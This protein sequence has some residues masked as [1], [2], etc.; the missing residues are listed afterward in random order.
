MRRSPCCR[1]EN[2]RGRSRARG[3]GARAEQALRVGP[4]RPGRRIQRGT[5]RDLRPRRPGR[6]GQNHPDAP[7]RGLAH[8]GF[9]HADRPRTRCRR[10]SAHRAGEHRL[11]AAALRTVRRPD[12]SG[13]PESLCRSAGPTQRSAGR[14]LCATPPH[15]RAGAIHSTIGGAPFR[16]H[17]TEAR[18]GLHAG[19]PP[20]TATAGRTDRRRRSRIPTRV[21]GDCVSTGCR[22]GHERPVVHGLS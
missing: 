14:A 16:W 11:H 15:D 1:R 17:E 3:A 13:K 10:R 9:R 4:R 18:S 8:T 6:R 20:S 12:R 19:S 5:G 21:V 7:H 22:R 2:E